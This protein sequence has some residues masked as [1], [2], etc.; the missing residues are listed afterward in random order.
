MFSGNLKMELILEDLAAPWS[1][2][3]K[4]IEKEDVPGYLI[5]RGSGG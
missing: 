3:V 4:D 1:L 5:F 2:D